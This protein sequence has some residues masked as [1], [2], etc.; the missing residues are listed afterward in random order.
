[1]YDYVDG[2]LSIIGGVYL[3][4]ILTNR[5]Q[6]ESRNEKIKSM[7]EKYKT[8]LKI[9]AILL[10]LYGITKLSDAYFELNIFL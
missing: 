1:M 5:L 6:I 4:L 9:M 2:I 8:A 7:F 10:T 3:Y